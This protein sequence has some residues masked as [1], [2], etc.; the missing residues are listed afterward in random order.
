MALFC[1]SPL[2]LFLPSY[3]SL[4]PQP[5][6]DVTAQRTTVTHADVLVED[7]LPQTPVTPI[8]SEAVNA[9]RNLFE[10]L[11]R[12]RR[13]RNV[14]EAEKAAK[15]ARNEARKVARG[16][17]NAIGAG[18]SEES[19]PCMQDL[20]APELDVAQGTL[21]IIGSESHDASE[22]GNATECEST[23]ARLVDNYVAEGRTACEPCKA[24]VARMW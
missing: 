21:A 1:Q 18:P 10:D 4:V 6:A 9:L 12:A 24:P 7:D 2:H 5:P 14:K 20:P 8:S 22:Q 23:T 15:K 3:F 13:Q 17:A 19:S 11:V 16:I